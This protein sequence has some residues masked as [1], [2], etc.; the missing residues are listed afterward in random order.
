MHGESS[1][2]KS[3]NALE[4][5]KYFPP[6]DVMILGYCTPQN[7]FYD[8]SELVDADGKRIPP[9]QDFLRRELIE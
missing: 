8:H 4:V 7:F 3:F 6:E 2:G 1:L 9:L 5:V